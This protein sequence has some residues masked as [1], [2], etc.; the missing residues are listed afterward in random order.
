MEAKK[1]KTLTVIIPTWNRARYLAKNLDILDSYLKRGLY[2]KILVCNNGST[3]GTKD[4]LK[5]Y[6]SHPHV[7]I[8]NH[9]ENIKFDRNVASGYLNFNTDYCFCLGDSKILSYESLEKIIITINEE[10]VDALIINVSKQMPTVCKYYNNVNNLMDE[11]GWSITNVSSCVIPKHF[12]S[13]ERCERYYDSLFIHFGVFID[14]LCALNNGFKV[15]YDPSIVKE[16]IHFT[17]EPQPH[18]WYSNVYHVWAKVWFSFI[19]SLPWEV[20]LDTKFKVIHDL[21]K[22]CGY[23]SFKKFILAKMNRDNK[24]LSDYNKDRILM[25]F[26]S[27]TPLWVYDVIVSIPSI[28][29]QC[30]KPLLI[31]SPRYKDKLI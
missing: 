25:P 27:T 11:M 8:I 28:F 5:K 4:V 22:H 29:F 19:M 21:N 16:M 17:D 1:K 7:R 31:L 12:I 23:L 26:V 9:P 24:F 15:K 14:A 10:D 30:L 13:V 20:T 3:D 6:E 2:F 18:G